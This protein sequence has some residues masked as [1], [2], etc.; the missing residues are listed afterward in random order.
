MDL[1]QFNFSILKKFDRTL[2]SNIERLVKNADSIEEDLSPIEL[3]GMLCEA[4][5][6]NVL[7]SHTNQVVD[8]GEDI[9]IT[10]AYILKCLSLYPL[11]SEIYKNW[12]KH[13]E[14]FDQAELTGFSEQSIAELHQFIQSIVVTGHDHTYLPLEKMRQPEH[15]LLLL[16]IHLDTILTSDSKMQPLCF[17][18]LFKFRFKKNKP[19]GPSSSFSDV[20]IYLLASHA[21]KKPLEKLP[22][23]SSFDKYLNTELL[24]NDSNNYDDEDHP[25]IKT[26]RQL[27]KKMRA[28]DRFCYLTDI[29]Q[30][31]T[32]PFNQ[33]ELIFDEL[34]AEITESNA[35]FLLSRTINDEDFVAFNDMNALWLIYYFQFLV[36]EAQKTNSPEVLQGL[37][38]TRE[39]MDLWKMF[40][41]PNGKKATFQ[42]PT[43]F[44]DVAKV[45]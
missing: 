35:R 9:K 6:L 40:Y 38:A 34:Y 26:M 13:V 30:F 37:S 33:I 18:Q 5:G 19:Y 22:S 23:I 39:F 1:T 3:K 42:W 10:F 36:Y 44:N 17:N 28:E 11:K 20:I 25:R 43:Q 45:T 2:E 12:N 15:L 27:L 14:L 32:T 41:V 29:D 21:N 8:Q 7:D 24:D 4:L 16:F 31:F